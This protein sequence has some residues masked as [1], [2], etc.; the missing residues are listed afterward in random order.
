MLVELAAE[1]AQAQHGDELVVG[2]RLRDR[3]DL[4][5]LGVEHLEHGTNS[6]SRRE[7]AVASGS[8]LPEP[9]T[10]DPE[11]ADQLVAQVRPGDDG[12]EGVLVGQLEDVDLG[13]DLAPFLLDEAGPLVRIARSPSPG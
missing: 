2:Q 10:V 1:D 3:S 8:A 7:H 12:F 5:A 11:A 13:L 4:D 6:R 9:A